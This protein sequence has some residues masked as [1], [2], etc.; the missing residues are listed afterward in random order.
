MYTGKEKDATGLYYY[1]ARYYDPQIG[2]FITRD[3]IKGRKSNS[4]TLNLYT[5][6]LNN[7]IKYIDPTGLDSMCTGD[8]ESRRCFEYTEK[9]WIAYDGEGNKIAS[10]AEIQEHL[11]QGNRLE[12]V[13]LILQALGFTID[14]YNDVSTED[15]PDGSIKVIIND[16]EITIKLGG[17]NKDKENP[18][19]SGKTNRPSNEGDPFSIHI[20]DS[21]FTSVNKLFHIVGHEMQ[22]AKHYAKGGLYWSWYRY[23]K[24]K[25]FNDSF[26]DRNAAYIS[27]M[28]A[29]RWNIMYFFMAPYEGGLEYTL[30][31]WMKYSE[32]VSDMFRT[33]GKP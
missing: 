3:I 10:S 8:G 7:P 32:S 25:G 19:A 31:Y 23:Y 33:Y 2:K 22:H 29:Y 13:M 17:T 1:G 16:T 20:Y 18:S 30:N 15:A 5:Y 21:A 14:S 12:A 6:C 27:E 11:D 26:A 28:L 24:G 4:Q 9:G